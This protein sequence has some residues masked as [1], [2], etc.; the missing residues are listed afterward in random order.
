M[1]VHEGSLQK[2]H[3]MRYKGL[4]LEVTGKVKEF[5]GVLLALHGAGVAEGLDDPEDDLLEAIRNQIGKDVPIVS[6]FDMH[7]NFTRKMMDHLDGLAGYNTFPH[8][9]V[10]ET[11]ERAINLTIPILEK[12]KG[13]RSQH[14]T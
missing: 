11:G 14:L 10:V 7:A 5:D 2:N 6:S 3:T 9:D 8:I 13:V 4:F 1:Q 12:K